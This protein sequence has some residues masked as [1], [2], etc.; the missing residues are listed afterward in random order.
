MIKFLSALL[1]ATLLLSPLNERIQSESYSLNETPASSEILT[2]RV[3]IGED[4]QN[5]AKEMGIVDAENVLEIYIS[6]NATTIE[7]SN[8]QP[9]FFKRDY[10]IKEDTIETTYETGKLIRR[11]EYQGPA[12]ATM[13][14]TETFSATFS[15]DFEVGIDELNTKLGYSTTS[16]FSVTDSYTVPVPDGKTYALECYVNNEKKT[17]EIWD[18]DLIFDN[19]VGVY[20]SI[21]PVGYVFIKKVV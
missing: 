5:Y 20:Y 13:S 17:F 6:N 21:R 10:Y 14:V 4:A 11:S 1:S 7:E 19:K 12:T 3:L 16:T 9:Y 18:K 8:V 15:F 2:G